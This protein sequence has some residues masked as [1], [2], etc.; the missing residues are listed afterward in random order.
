LIVKMFRTLIRLFMVVPYIQ[1]QMNAFERIENDFHCI[2][3]VEQ[4]KKW[5][6]EFKPIKEKVLSEHPDRA[7]KA[8][9]LE[10]YGYNRVFSNSLRNMVHAVGAYLVYRKK[11]D[12]IWHL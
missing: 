5:L 7:Q 12:W 8:K 1:K 9:E 11:I 10:N 4:L 3:N 6:G 2:S